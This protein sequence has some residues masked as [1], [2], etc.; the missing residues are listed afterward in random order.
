MKELNKKELEL[1]KDAIRCQIVTAMDNS[2]IES[3][4]NNERSVKRIEKYIKEL[5]KIYRK[6]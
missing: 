4:R 1:L 2:Y 6:L 3:K 5:E